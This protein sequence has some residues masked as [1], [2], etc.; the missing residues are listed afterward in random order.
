MDRYYTGSEDYYSH[1]SLCWPGAFPN[2]C[3]NNTIGLDLSINREVEH[4]Y[5]GNYST[6]LYTEKAVEIIRKH[7][8]TH[9]P[10]SD[11]TPMFLYLPHQAVHVG[12]RPGPWGGR[13]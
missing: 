8:D 11:D 13:L 4:E 3:F 6:E 9:G 10:S 7:A 2:G 12:N 1:Q 5:R